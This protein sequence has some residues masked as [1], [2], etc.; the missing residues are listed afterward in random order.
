MRYLGMR[1]LTRF[2][3]GHHPGPDARSPSCTGASTTASSPSWRRHPRPDA[4]WCPTGRPAVERRSRPTMPGAPNS[5]DSWAMTFLNAAPARSTRARR[6]SSATSSVRWCSGLPKEPSADA[7]TW[8][9]QQSSRLRS[10]GGRV[11][12][13]GVG[14]DRL[15]GRRHPAALAGRS[16]RARGW[17]ARLVAPAAVPARPGPALP[18]VP[19]ADAVRRPHREAR[20]VVRNLGWCRRSTI[21]DVSAVARSSAGGQS[22]PPETCRWARPGFPPCEGAR[23]QRH[24]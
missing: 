2:L 7:V 16:P 22:G 4:R 23:P 18:R 8:A 3:A 9:E 13:A 15:V 19:D 20:H 14:A 1:T 6:R 5:S 17:P 11:A 12:S 10:G 24:L 21:S